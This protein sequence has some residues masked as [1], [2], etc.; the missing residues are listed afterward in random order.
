M[1]DIDGR[2][3]DPWVVAVFRP[4][5]RKQWWAKLLPWNWRK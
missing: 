1:G 2:S 3:R 4:P 5:I